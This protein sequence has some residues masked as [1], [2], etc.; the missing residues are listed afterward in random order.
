MPSTKEILRW[1]CIEGGYPERMRPIVDGSLY[2]SQWKAPRRAVLFGGE[3]SL[4]VVLEVLAPWLD[5]ILAITRISAPFLRRLLRIPFNFLLKRI[6]T[7]RARHTLGDSQKEYVNIESPAL[8]QEHALDKF[9]AAAERLEKQKW[10]HADK[11]EIK[12]ALEL[13]HQLRV[14]GVPHTKITG[15]IPWSRYSKRQGTYPKFEK[16]IAA[17]REAQGLTDDEVFNEYCRISLELLEIRETI[18]RTRV[19]LVSRRAILFDQNLKQT[20]TLRD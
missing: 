18:E 2:A 19:M 14:L 3:F 11:D 15:M 5:P 12:K 7:F 9:S 4:A 6:P 20:P 17:L 8:P 10:I 16:K 1:F 13:I